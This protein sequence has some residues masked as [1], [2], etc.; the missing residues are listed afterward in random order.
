MKKLSEENDGDYV[1]NVYVLLRSVRTTHCL[2]Q[3]HFQLTTKMVPRTN[4]KSG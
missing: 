1:N 4:I 3:L 2:Q